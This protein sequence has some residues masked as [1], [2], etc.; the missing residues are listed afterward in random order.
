MRAKA[1]LSEDF[2]SS[3]GQEPN[4]KHDTARAFL[5]GLID[6]AGLFP[7]AA[8]SMDAAL[9][10]HERALASE[11]FWLVGRFVVS[12]SKFDEMALALDDAPR[13]LA[14]AVV[15]DGAMDLAA[16]LQALG[17][18]ARTRVERVAVEALEV[19]FARLAGETD[20][21]RLAGLERLL[22]TAD[23]PGQPDV[24]V[25]MSLGDSA[26][27]Q[28]VALERAR[29]RGFAAA[30]KIRCG[31]LTASA[32][33][34][35]SAVAHVLWTANRA[36]V[37]LKATAGLHH[38]LPFDDPSIGARTHGFLNLIGGAVLARARGIDRHTL[39]TLLTDR[40]AANFRLDAAHFSWRGIGA[41]AAEVGEARA[42]FV[43][44]YGS[45][46]LEEPLAD[47]RELAL[48]PALA[49]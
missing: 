12:A 34:A 35:P 18:T 5:G 47:L 2:A 38:A 19:P 14:V 6:D 23:V 9:A 16:V 36:N 22:A 48:L 11:A 46:S 29:G 39:E 31:G 13:P 33:P 49:R 20:D 25:E 41:D 40:E 44:S 7:P 3:D 4:V 42:N 15:V 21:E 10:A 37:P 32:V 1:V 27:Q 17:R 28:L 30:A 24:Y 43:H 26:E 8:L 45:C